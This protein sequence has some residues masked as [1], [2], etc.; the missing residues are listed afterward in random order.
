MKELRLSGVELE[1]VAVDEK[2]GSLSPEKGKARSQVTID[3]DVDDR[4]LNVGGTMHGGCTA[5]L[6]DR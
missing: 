4:M 3:L 1:N 6:L 5:F 2:T